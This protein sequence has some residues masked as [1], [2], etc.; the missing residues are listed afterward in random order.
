MRNLITILILC[1]CLPVFAADATKIHSHDQKLNEEL[2]NLYYQINNNF[3]DLRTTAELVLIKPSKV[4]EHY[5]NT[6]TNE[7]WI[8]TG[9]LVNQFI[10]K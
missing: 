10:H 4:G 7:L 6:T 1:M 2:D 3:F 8:A 5:F 9:T